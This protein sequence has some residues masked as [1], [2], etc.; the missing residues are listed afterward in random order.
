MALSLCVFCLCISALLYAANI[1]LGIASYATGPVF[2]ESASEVTFPVSEG[3]SN[4][5]LAMAANILAF[6][7]YMLFFIPNIGE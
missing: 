6:V 7:F 4:T 2:C 5:V 1:C 3:V